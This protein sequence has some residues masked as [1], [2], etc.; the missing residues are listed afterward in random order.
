[1][2]R[3]RFTIAVLLL[4]ALIVYLFVQAPPPLE[5]RS[6]S[7][8]SI[9]IEKVFRMVAAENARVREL[10]TNEIVREG[11][12]RGLKFSEAWSERGVEAGPLP[13][14]FLRET[15]TSLEKDPVRLSL[16]LGS[17]F[18]IAAS[19][20]F[21]GAQG[22]HFRRVRATRT[23]VFFHAPDLNMQVA[24]FP[25]V[26]VSPACVSCHNQH[27]ESPKKDWAL[28]QIM[29]AVTWMYP[30]EAVS[31][32]ELIE[33]LLALRRGF[34][35]AYTQYVRKVGTFANPPEIGKQ[36][37]KDGYYVPDVDTFMEEVANRAS[38]A[39]L[40]AVIET[41]GHEGAR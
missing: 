21:A 9:P 37:P 16:F 34:R 32:D 33:I 5:D 4:T 2:S 11:T 23:A 22:E 25:D 8:E 20:R 3:R 39:T 19:N 31:S 30:R 12:A 17:D 26:A 1:M 28:D 10:W 14:L 18:P 36:W 7:G 38:R 29:G 13:A 15:A 6:A 41:G 24:M 27:P 35:Y 40:D